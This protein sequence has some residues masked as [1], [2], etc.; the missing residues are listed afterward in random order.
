MSLLLTGLLGFWGVADA[1]A[2]TINGMK[3]KSLTAQM[4]EEEEEPAEPMPGDDVGQWAPDLKG[5]IGSYLKD[6]GV[7]VGTSALFIAGQPA[8]FVFVQRGDNLYR[9]VDLYTEGFKPTAYVCYGLKTNTAD[10]K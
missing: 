3:A 6:G 9:C 10:K 2:L 4:Q 8:L 1:H 5:T 7:V